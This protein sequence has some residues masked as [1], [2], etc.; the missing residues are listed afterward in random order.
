MANNTQIDA[1]QLLAQIAEQLQSIQADQQADREAHQQQIRMLQENIA[2]MNQQRR[3]PPLPSNTDEPT[4]LPPLPP[5]PATQRVITPAPPATTSNS[6]TI[7]RK[8]KPTLPDPPRFDGS[9]RKF[10]TWQLEMKSKLRTDGTA[11]GSEADQFAYIYSRLDQTP[12]AMAAAYFEIGGNQGTKDPWDF[13]KYLAASYA[14]PNIAQR[15][16]SRLEALKQ[17]EKESFAAF[18]PK[19]EKELADSGGSLWSS[20]VQ[21]NHL[22]RVINQEL[23]TYLAGQLNLPQTYPEYVRALQDLGT[24]LDDLRFHS[25]RWN[26]RS[27]PLQARELANDRADEMEWEPTKVNQVV[28]QKDDQLRGKRAKWVE[29]DEIRKRRAEHRCVRCGR[30]ECRISKCP[31]LPARRPQTAQVAKVHQAMIEEEEEAHTN[32][33]QL[34]DDSEKE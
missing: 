30:S 4:N 17:G 7:I 25:K 28:P 22:K 27:R 10:R 13:L 1:I 31:L 32:P 3:T 33:D 19:F 14:D 23:R 18:L 2:A 34:S 8:K 12:Q 16:L 15:A 9:R 29:I 11:I 6:A 24:N 20:D 21:I 26:P 5:S